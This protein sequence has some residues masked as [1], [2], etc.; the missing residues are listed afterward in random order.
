[1]AFSLVTLVLVQLKL[2]VWFEPHLHEPEVFTPYTK[3]Y[4]RAIRPCY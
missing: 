3:Y 4:V 1:M 2:A